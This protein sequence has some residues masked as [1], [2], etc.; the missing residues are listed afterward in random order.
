MEKGF[1]LTTKKGRVASFSTKTATGRVVVGGKPYRFSLTSF[2]NASPN[3]Y[4]R[5]GQSVEAVFSQ[6]GNRLVSLWA[7]D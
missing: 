7:N 2:R 4:P 5:S 3:R 6:N 1:K